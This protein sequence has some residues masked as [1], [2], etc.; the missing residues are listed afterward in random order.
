[1]IAFLFQDK[2]FPGRLRLTVNTRQSLTSSQDHWLYRYRMSF[3][4][5]FEFTAVFVMK[6]NPISS[7]IAV[8]VFLR[9][10]TESHVVKNNI[11]FPHSNKRANAD[12][13]HP[14]SRP[15]AEYAEPIQPIPLPWSLHGPSTIL[16]FI[17]A[18]GLR[19]MEAAGVRRFR[20]PSDS[21]ATPFPDP[22]PGDP[23]IS[24]PRGDVGYGAQKH[25]PV[26][27]TRRVIWRPGAHQPQ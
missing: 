14:Q 5:R 27:R 8:C 11:Y 20:R 13:L 9:P 2:A 12:G 26:A 18:L 19:S 1:M 17:G 15:W 21:P 3:F 10:V 6:L 24:G 4:G 7:I 16:P 23:G 25:G 22:L